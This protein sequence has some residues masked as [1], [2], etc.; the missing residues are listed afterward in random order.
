MCFLNN[1]LIFLKFLNIFQK[2]LLV[3][4]YEKINSDIRKCVLNR[5]FAIGV[6]PD[7]INYFW[8]Q[9]FL[10]IFVLGFSNYKP[11]CDWQVRRIFLC[12]KFLRKSLKVEKLL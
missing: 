4:N 6:V 8:V 1:Y 3:Q 9:K 5:N 2:C 12:P 10:Q 11:F 7:F